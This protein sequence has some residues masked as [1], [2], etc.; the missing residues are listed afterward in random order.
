MPSKECRVR[1]IIE[2][3][4]LRYIFWGRLLSLVVFFVSRNKDIVHSEIVEEEEPQD[5]PEDVPFGDI[6]EEAQGDHSDL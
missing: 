4:F 1:D 3:I 2:C 5:H 6:H